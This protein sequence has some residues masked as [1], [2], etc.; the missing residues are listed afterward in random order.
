MT[1][2]D[3]INLHNYIHLFL[4]KTADTIVTRRLRK[5]LKSISKSLTQFTED[6]ED[7]MALHC[8]KGDKGEIILKDKEFTF[9]VEGRLAFRK[10]VKKLKEKVIELEVEKVDWKL[11][12]EDEKKLIALYDESTH[13]ICKLFINGLPEYSGDEP[14]IG[15]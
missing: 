4:Q 8:L 15:S 3:L 14:I 2:L 13:D 1:N 12:T 9:T 11:F 5:T 7:L 6:E 10:D